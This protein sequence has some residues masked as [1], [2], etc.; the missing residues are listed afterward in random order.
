[1][2]QIPSNLVVARVGARRWL[3]V[4]LLGWGTVAAC[5]SL[6]HNVASFFALRV[7]LGLFEAGA[8]P[9]MWLHL[10]TFFPADRCVGHRVYRQTLQHA[11]HYSI[12]TLGCTSAIGCS[13]FQALSSSW[14]AALISLL[15]LS[16]G[17]PILSQESC[18]I[19]TKQ[20]GAAIRGH[21]RQ[22]QQS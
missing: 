12:G 10:A 2:L 15:F 22:A 16:E 9:A 17:R 18:V 14:V 5:M 20:P 6:I 1:M 13:T 7:L 19:L 21:A 11:I 8:V 4:L 3:A